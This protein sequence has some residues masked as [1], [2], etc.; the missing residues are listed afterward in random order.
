[1]Q[2]SN[3]NQNHMKTI[4]SAILI[5][6]VS[7]ISLPAWCQKSGSKDKIKSIVVTEE[8]LDMLVKKQFKESETYYDQKGNV[9]EEITYKEGKVTKHFKY[10]YDADDNKIR[11]EEYEPSGR[12]KEYSEYKYE[13]G[14][15]V[16]KLVYDGNNKLKTRK[17][18]NYT[19][20]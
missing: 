16:E 1:M 10:Q 18:Y 20:Y 12:I 13:N 5:I 11:E 15:R 3:Q 7:W 19:L 14:R 4:R 9:T 2:H 8:K 6:L 17:T